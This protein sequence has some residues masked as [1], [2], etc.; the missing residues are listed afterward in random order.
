MINLEQNWGPMLKTAGKEVAL[1]TPAKTMIKG[2]PGP[3]QKV[4]LI[5]DPRYFSRWGL[6]LAIVGTSGRWFLSSLWAQNSKT[7]S[8]DFGQKYDW[9]NP[10]EVY[11]EVKKLV[12]MIPTLK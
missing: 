10:L 6:T 11:K 8:I 7:V 12:K 1:H 9:V 2:Q 4:V 5:E 3:D